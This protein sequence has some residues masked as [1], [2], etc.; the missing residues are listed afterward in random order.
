MRENTHRGAPRSGRLAGRAAAGRAARASGAGAPGSG[1][2]GRDGTKRSAASG[3]GQDVRATSVPGA[4]PGRAGSAAEVGRLT[5]LLRPVLKALDLDLEEIKLGTAGRRRVLRVIVDADGGVSLDDIAEASREISA[6]LD[7]RNAMR[8]A[9]YTLEV[10]SPGVDRPLTEP[11][12]WRRATGR[13][14]A[15]PVAAGSRDRDRAVPGGQGT[16][17]GRVIEAGGNGVILQVDG[18]TRTLRYSDIGAGRVQVEFGRPG[19]DDV[20]DDRDG[21]VPSEGGQG[22]DRG[23]DATDS[24]VTWADGAAGGGAD[25][26]GP[27]GY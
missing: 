2:P 14:V 24:D 12:H 1:R 23:A 10:S 13:L 21:L 6:T 17:T 15:V 11:R 19:A 8:E 5:S 26:E 9:S 22:D 16:L 18:V 7:A 25:E 20:G 3:A 27:D 4:Q